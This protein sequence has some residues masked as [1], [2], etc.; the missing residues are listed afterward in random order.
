MSR[1]AYRAGP[2]RR[3]L[4]FRTL[5]LLCVLAVLAVAVA[6]FADLLGCLDRCSV[7]LAALH[8]RV[9]TLE[10]SDTRLNAWILAWVQHALVAQP[11]DLF[12]ANILHPAPD[13]LAGSEHLIGLALPLLPLRLFA[14]DAIAIHG[15]A[16]VSSSALL[17]LGTF[18]LVRWLSGSLL[19]A[20]AAGVASLLM[21]WRMAEIGRVQLFAAHWFPWV[22]LFALRILLGEARLRDRLAL[23]AVLTLQLLTSFYL[24]YELCLSLALLAFSAAWLAAVPARAWL[25]FGTAALPAFALFGLSALPYLERQAR[26][27]IVVTS[28]PAPVTLLEAVGFWARFLS[29]PADSLFGAW[30]SSKPAY[31]VPVSVA[32]L[33][34]AALVVATASGRGGARERR[35]RVAVAGLF[36]CVATAFVLCMGSHV[37]WGDGQLDLPGGWAARLVPGYD[38]LRAPHRWS[39]AIGLAAPVLAGLGLAGFERRL[40]ARLGARFPR[41][42]R[43]VPAGL[44]AL[45][46]AD[47]P[48]TGRLPVAS[49]G[50]EPERVADLGTALG[51]LPF[52]PVLEIPWPAFAIRTVDLDTQY[53]LAS[54]RHWRPLLNG[55]TAHLPPSFFLLHR[56]AQGL[57]SDEALGLLSRLTDLRWIVVHADLLGPDERQAWERAAADGRLARAHKGV[58]VSIFEVPL[59]G[60]TAEWMPALLAPSA[61]HTLAGLPRAPLRLALE[62]GQLEVEET[63]RFRSLGLAGLPTPIQMRI[64]NASGVAWPGLDVLRDGLV[65][66][67]VTFSDPTDGVV[68]V[69]NVPLD[70]DIPAAASVGLAPLVRSPR[71]RSGP[72]RLCLDLVQV[73][74]ADLVPLPVPPVEIEVIV[75]PYSGRRQEESGLLVP[76]SPLPAQAPPGAV[77]PCA[78]EPQ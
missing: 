56:I 53:M 18:L 40:R 62:A 39:I 22:W 50:R 69:T 60:D 16:L 23:C 2:R 76:P 6:P 59:R 12:Q 27:E 15:A 52:G 25:R 14:G 67:R 32:L 66:L 1:E 78:G 7:D 34:A 26:G 55:F 31:F 72:L 4:P 37:S 28:E 43:V 77:S 45:L 20:L 74:G 68:E 64:R 5:T 33:A 42:A 49:L 30:G 48:W 75:T 46:L 10:Q 73:L 70:R 58:P 8:G 63:P 61:T 19:A 36:G 35:E 65:E 47:L 54:T 11:F 21:P 57:P 38:K 51:S 13:V 17:G 44:A 24:D 9:G 71:A 3:G 29:P 41:S